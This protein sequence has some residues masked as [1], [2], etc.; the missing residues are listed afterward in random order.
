METPPPAPTQSQVG[1]LAVSSTHGW[2]AITPG[3][4][5]ACI[6]PTGYWSVQCSL[7]NKIRKCEEK[8]ESGSSH[9]KTPAFKSLHFIMQSLKWSPGVR[10]RPSHPTHHQTQWNPEKKG[11]K[12]LRKCQFYWHQ[13]TTEYND[14]ERIGTC[15]IEI[16]TTMRTVIVSRYYTILFFFKSQ[17][18]KCYYYK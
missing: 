18:L 8:V 6:L 3:K 11:Q 17:K 9:W 5:K 10:Q 12:L 13:C 16:V 2:E 14:L 4:T 1:Q 7:K 15:E